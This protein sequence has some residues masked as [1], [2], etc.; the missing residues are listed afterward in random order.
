MWD[1]GHWDQRYSAPG[2]QFGKEPA[3]FLKR[4]SA[5]LSQ[6]ANILCVADGEGRNSVFLAALGH[7]V[8]AFDPSPFAVEKARQLAGERQV[9]PQF[10]V[11]TVEDWDWDQTHDVVVAIFVQFAPPDLRERLFGWL[12]G[13]VAPGGLLLLHGYVPRQLE[14]KTGG[15]P[16]AS[17]MYTEAMLADAFDGFDILRLKEYDAEIY[18]GPGHSGRSALIDLAARKPDL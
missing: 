6:P 5:R 10:N 2:Y 14:Y 9:E 4:E 8:T 1:Q 16:D 15:P 13:A 3:Q 11:A 12:A 17:H 7:H 18:E